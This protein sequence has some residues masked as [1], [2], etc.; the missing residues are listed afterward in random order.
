M[1]NLPFWFPT[2]NN[3]IWYILFIGLFI[4][5][6]DFWGWNQSNP[7]ILG[8][9]LWVVYLFILTLAISIVFYFFSKTYWE[10]SQ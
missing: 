4:L 3:V 10:D 6:M 2:K 5:S 9:P 1:K 7:L 8:L